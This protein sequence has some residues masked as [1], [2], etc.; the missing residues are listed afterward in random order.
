VGS[1][2]LTFGVRASCDDGRGGADV[3]STAQPPAN[4][5][6]KTHT[7]AADRIFLARVIFFG[8]TARA[9]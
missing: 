3:V 5:R 8:Q 4:A 6:N 7:E 9:R 2:G 1:S